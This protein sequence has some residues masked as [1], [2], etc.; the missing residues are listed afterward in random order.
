MKFKWGVRFKGGARGPAM[1]AGAI[2]LALMMMFPFL[3]L[4]WFRASEN[5]QY[6]NS[7]P[8]PVMPGTDSDNDGLYDN[9]EKKVGT[10][11]YKPDTDSDKFNDGQEYNYWMKRYSAEK[12][13]PANMTAAWLLEKYPNESRAQLLKRYQPTGDLDGDGLPN[14]RDPDSDGDGV[15]DGEEIDQGTDPADPTNSGAGNQNPGGDNSTWNNTGS[16][17][18]YRPGSANLT[19]DH[20]DTSAFQ[21]ISSGETK[22]LFYVDPPQ[23]PRYWR[24]TAYDTYVNGSWTIRSPAKM[25]YNGD[26]LPQ[27]IDRPPSVSED[28]YRITYNGNGTGF[29]P[30]ALHTTTLTGPVP[31]VSISLDRMGNFATPDFIESYDFRTFALPLTSQ[32]LESAQLDASRVDAGLTDVPDTVPARDRALAASIAGGAMA[33][34]EKVKAVLT[35]LKTNCLFT[36]HPASVP[37][38]EDPVD[39]FLF[40]TRQGSSLE[41]ASAFVTLCRYNGIPCRFVTGFAIGDV[42][43]GRREVR[44]G[45]FHAW[46]EVLFVNLGWVQ[47]ETANA[48]LAGPPSDVGADGSDPTVGDVD[49][50]NGTII[51]GGTGGGTTENG[52]GHKN[53]TVQNGSFAIRFQVDRYI[54]MK[55]SIFTVSGMLLS[56]YPLGTGASVNVYLN[57]SDRVV[58]RSKTGP[59]GAFSVLCNADGLPIGR[60]MVGLTASLEDRNILRMAETAPQAMKEIQLCSNTTLE[61]VSKD[62]AIGAESFEYSVRLRDAGGLASPW[63]EWTDVL[64]NGSFVDRVEASEKE[65]SETLDIGTPPGTYNITAVYNGSLFLNPSNVTKPIHVKSGGLRMEVS[66]F[67]EAP[68]TGNP[69]FVDVYLADGQGRSLKE[70]VTISLDGKA[71]TFGPAG[72]VLKVELAASVV[73]SGHHKLN[74]KYPGN[75]AF[76][77]VSRDVDLVVKGTSALTLAPGSVSLGTSKML[78]GS[79]VD[80]LGEPIVGV[81]VTVTWTDPRG[82]NV[83]AQNLTYSEGDFHYKMVTTKDMPPG[84]VLVTATFPGDDRYAGSGNT[85][86]IQLT[87]PSV[88]NATIPRD[89]TR[90]MAYCATGSLSDHLGKPIALSRVTLQRGE[91]LWGV[92]WT[93]NAGAFSLVF[94][95]PRSE[96]TG[97]AEADLRYAGENYRESAFEGFN[98]S[99]FTATFINLTVDGKLEQGGAFDV[100]AFLV[101]DRDVALPGAKLGIS[102]AGTERTQRTDAYGRAVFP[103]RFPYLTTKEN[104]RIEYK[105]G[106]YSRPASSARSLAGEPV[107]YYRVLAVLAAAA[108][109]A[110][111]YYVYR[112][113]RLGQRPE[114]T[115]VEMLDRSWI[116]DKYRKTIFK[117]YTRMLGRMRDMGHPRMEAWTV[118]EYQRELERQLRLD[119]QSL[120]LLTLIFEEARYSKHKLDGDISRRAVQSYRALVNSVEPPPSEQPYGE[121]PVRTQNEAPA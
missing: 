46:A 49:A 54:V 25:A 69:I 3:P 58:G 44:A 34:M 110:T 102:F 9:L 84:G 76:A 85:T 86:Y 68:V 87:S 21:N 31:P 4:P 115:L 73:G 88:F 92:G 41:F 10:D 60:W 59:D 116:S 20:V 72:S 112:R 39:H 12:N 6:A 61:I 118:H 111:A 50:T 47:F 104:L 17:D 93:D 26:Y 15:L 103:V 64:W 74:V 45:H 117:V 22:V 29:L 1:A 80:N 14:I 81:H 19:N 40:T 27:E 2:F 99:I 8:E 77:E 66:V 37:P 57:E 28:G 33:P 48:E 13:Q 52:T 78:A 114:E 91:T 113:L 83:T 100:V 56:P 70:N 90:G 63:T 119:M 62:Y 97:P 106:A 121:M 96:D 65:G 95:V 16:Q 5:I 23:K 32:E 75:D 79:L 120:S 24:I 82:S 11:P 107:V 7:R 55:G 89:L 53:L 101:D 67:P 43:D 30:N 109:I 42:A 108:V 35:Y 51:I 94:E 71:K 98:V 36:N 18:D 105:G 38:G